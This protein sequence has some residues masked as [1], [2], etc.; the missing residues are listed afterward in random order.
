VDEPETA[1]FI[2]TDYALR[3]GYEKSHL[4]TAFQHMKANLLTMKRDHLG[5]TERLRLTSIGRL[6]IV[7]KVAITVCNLEIKATSRQEP[8]HLDVTLMRCMKG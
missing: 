7:G 2:E 8:S 6:V 5:M 1:R 4:T 3:S